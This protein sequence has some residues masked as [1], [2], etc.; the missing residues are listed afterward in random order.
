MIVWWQK[1]VSIAKLTWD[2]ELSHRNHGGFYKGVPD[3]GQ[4]APGHEPRQIVVFQID[5]AVAF[6][7]VNPAHVDS[8]KEI[9]GIVGEVAQVVRQ[10]NIRV[11]SGGDVEDN[12]FA[13]LLGFGA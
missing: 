3:A 11:E 12:P 7:E 9:T 4:H 5:E 10:M 6:T 8:V 1:P 2:A 13:A